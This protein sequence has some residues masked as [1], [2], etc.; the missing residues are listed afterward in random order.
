[1]GAVTTVCVPDSTARDA[2]APVPDGVRVVVWD[3]TGDPPAGIEQTSFLLGSY[4]GA[5]AAAHVVAAMPGLRVIQLLSAGVEA[6]LPLVPN[7]VTLCNGRGV[8]GSGTAELAVAGIL[9]ITRQMPYF[10]S[11]QAERRHRAAAAP[12][13]CFGCLARSRSR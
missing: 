8:H 13:V 3:G 1:M 2:I 4:M 11:A 12:P 10:L 5:P 9:A 6:W 7:G